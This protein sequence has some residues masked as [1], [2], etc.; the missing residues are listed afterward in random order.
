VA[1]ANLLLRVRSFLGRP[2]VRFASGSLGA[3][4]IVL[5]LSLSTMPALHPGIVHL[6]APSAAP[7][8]RSTAPT[9]WAIHQGHS[10][11]IR[12]SAR[13]GVSPTPGT[14]YEV[15]NFGSITSGTNPPPQPGYCFNFTLANSTFCADPPANATLADLGLNLTVATS[16]ASG[17][18]PV[19][20]NFTWNLTVNGGGLPPYLVQLVIYDAGMTY[21][22]TNLTGSLN[23]TLP[24]IYYV[25]V[26]AE[27]SSC[28]QTAYSSF[29]V[30]AFDPALGANPVHI[31]AVVSSPTVPSNVTY[32]VN[33]TGIPSNITVLWISPGFFSTEVPN[34]TGVAWQMYFLPGTYAAAACLES[35]GPNGTPTG[36]NLGCGI[37]PNVTLGGI[38]P[39]TTNVSVAAGAFP[40]NVTFTVNLV[41]S[42]G[43]PN[44]TEL[45]LIVYNPEWPHVGTW[46]L[47]NT[48][49]VSLT[50]PEGCGRPW[51]TYVPPNGICPIVATYSLQDP[52][53][54]LD[55]GGLGYGSLVANLTANGTPSL[56][57][58][59]VS[60]SY[61]PLNGSL[62]FNLTVNLT[63]TNGQAPYTYSS[64]VYG[65][66]S[67]TANASRYPTINSTGYNWNGSLLS[68]GFTFN[69]TGIY[70]LSIFVYDSDDAWVG[71]SLPLIILGNV[72][73]LGPLVISATGGGGPSGGGHLEASMSSAFVAS[74]KGGIGPFS[75]QW[76]FGD[77]TYGSSI[78]GLPVYHAYAA[79]GT[80]VAKVTVR[81]G[82]GV[83]VITTLAS[84]T[85]VA[86]PDQAKITGPTLQGPSSSPAGLQWGP[87]LWAG[88]IGVGLLAMGTLA[89][90]EEVRRQGEALVSGIEDGDDEPSPDDSRVR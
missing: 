57:N 1:S 48:S 35:E 65:R 84:I 71:F 50:M 18:G 68:L 51:T 38:S 36:I 88:V 17:V 90:R 24:G 74:T 89:A 44:D 40:T 60:Y 30:D 9:S 29:T 72:S 16:P 87:V 37:S 14:T 76:S 28:S 77:G 8:T 21:L 70:Y 52:S 85:V 10:A 5:L 20:M 11:P 66:A 46:N 59:S 41:N 56:W 22:T 49:T 54:S 86:N 27:D 2:T 58:P 23:L 78:P 79:P 47:S 42:T 81:D 32:I 82:R 12:S 6:A 73:A 13:P 45:Y 25:D 39:V 75:I 15:C 31:S 67:G 62:P 80:Y 4:A 53:R 55:S 34:V 19:P 61:G 63:A 83:V 69:R 26:M 33:M 7:S 3:V 43:M 64:V